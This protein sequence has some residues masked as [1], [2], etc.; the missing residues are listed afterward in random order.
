MRLAVS[1]GVGLFVGCQPLYGL[2]LPLCVL[3]CVPLR[4]DAVAAYLA[5]NISNP[6]LAPLLLVL[7]VNVGSLVLTG[8]YAALS[9]D[10]ARQTGISGLVV[11]A[12]VGSVLVGATLAAFGS[13]AAWLAAS[14]ARGCHRR[15]EQPVSAPIFESEQVGVQNLSQHL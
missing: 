8:G 6:A 3:L 10:Q 5:A 9:L 7:Q 12:T 11:Q 1:V 4:L 14:H 2:H 15:R 13:V